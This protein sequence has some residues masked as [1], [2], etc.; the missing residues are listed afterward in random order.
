LTRWAARPVTDQQGYR[1][2]PGDIAEFQVQ[3]Q[4]ELARLG[5]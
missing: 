3:L 4:N 2:S 5:F 1:P